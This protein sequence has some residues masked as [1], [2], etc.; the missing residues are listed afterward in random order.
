M[1]LEKYNNLLKE[2]FEE[3]EIL[4][5]KV[6]N[7]KDDLFLNNLRALREIILECDKYAPTFKNLRKAIA[8]VGN[9]DLAQFHSFYDYKFGFAINEK[10]CYSVSSIV[11]RNSY[12]YGFSGLYIEK[13]YNGSNQAFSTTPKI[14]IHYIDE[15]LTDIKLLNYN[16]YSDAKIY[17]EDNDYQLND[18]SY[19]N[20]CAFYLIKSLYDITKKEGYDLKK[21]FGNYKEKIEKYMVVKL[22]ELQNENTTKQKYCN[23]ML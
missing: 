12:I 21:S 1:N 15:I 14:L 11:G 20:H 10:L 13:S 9:I 16:R 6:A 3:K 22:T 18:Y 19:L 5:N 23:E 7:I 2:L 8:C 4:D 17:Y